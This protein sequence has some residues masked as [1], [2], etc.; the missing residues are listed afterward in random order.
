MRVHAERGH[1][2][3]G[4]RVGRSVTS[5]RVRIV[6]SSLSSMSGEDGGAGVRVQ[7]PPSRSLVTL[8]G[9]R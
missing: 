8:V 7:R 6:F 3:G 5:V 4:K 9:R 2:V 1:E